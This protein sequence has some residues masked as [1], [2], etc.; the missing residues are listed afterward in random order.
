MK[1]QHA[2]YTLV[3]VMAAVSIV[4]IITAVAM[5][6][7]TGY[8]KRGRLTEAFTGLGAGQTAAEQF[9]ANNRTYSGFSSSASFPKNGNYFE[10]TLS[11]AGTS[12][13]TLTATGKDM[14]TGFAYTIDQN[15]NRK[16]TSVPAGWTSS[17]TCWVDRENGKCAN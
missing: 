3:E 16:T 2:G 17:G 10:F 7:Y 14:L 5:P 4:A 8:V 6:S 13:Y 12:G 9:W 11:D 1:R 15:G